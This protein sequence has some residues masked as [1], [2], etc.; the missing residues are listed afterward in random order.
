MTYKNY[1]RE[2]EE[3]GTTVINVNITEEDIHPFR[4][5]RVVAAKLQGDI[6]LF[7][8]GEGQ[9]KQPIFRINN[10]FH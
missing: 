5:L 3:S 8:P 6:E 1:L 2:K 7:T 9:G 4:F 10:A